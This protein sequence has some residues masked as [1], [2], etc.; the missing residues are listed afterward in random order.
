[1]AL[2]SAIVNQGET[3]LDDR[4]DV[5]LRDPIG[6]VLPRMVAASSTQR[7]GSDGSSSP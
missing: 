4:A 1:M 3:S 6:E 5:V 7:P 2:D